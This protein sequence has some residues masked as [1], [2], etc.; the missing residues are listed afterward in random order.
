MSLSS[1]PVPKRLSPPRGGQLDGSHPLSG[2]RRGEASWSSSWGDKQREL[3][4]EGDPR[5]RQSRLISLT[6]AQN[7][8]TM[9]AK[10][11]R[12]C[13][14][15]WRSSE[16]A[17]RTCVCDLIVPA[18]GGAGALK[19]VAKV[20]L[21]YHF[22]ELFR[23]SN[24]GTVITRVFPSQTRRFVKDVSEDEAAL[25]ARLGAPD[26]STPVVLYP[27][28]GSVSVAE[29]KEMVGGAAGVDVD[30]DVGMGMGGDDGVQGGGGGMGTGVCAAGLASEPPTSSPGSAAARVAERY[31]QL[32]NAHD[33][34]GMLAMYAD[35]GVD[36]Y[37]VAGRA[38]DMARVAAAQRT[39]FTR[40][41]PTLRYEWGAIT[42]VT[43]E[44]AAPA[45]VAAVVEFAF[46]RHWVEESADGAQR[47]MR[48]DSLEH[49]MVERVHVHRATGKVERV[50]V[51]GAGGPASALASA[52]ALEKKEDE[53]KRPQHP[54][55]SH[56]EET[57]SGTAA[58]TAAAA[59]S[60][61]EVAPTV[62]ATAAATTA[63]T[64]AATASP[65]FHL[66]LLDG[67]WDQARKLNKGID[68]SIPRVR[69]EQER[70]SA[71]ALRKQ[72]PTDRCRVSTCEA[73][74]V[75]LEELGEGPG[76]TAAIDAA[77]QLHSHGRPGGFDPSLNGL[78]VGYGVGSRT[79]GQ[80]T[81]QPRKERG[82]VRGESAGMGKGGGS[83]TGTG[84]GTGE[85]GSINGPEADDSNWTHVYVKGLPVWF[86]EV[87]L[88][89]LFSAFGS[90][91][92]THV[93]MRGFRRKKRAAQRREYGG[94]ARTARTAENENGAAGELGERGEVRGEC[95]GF[96]FVNYT[97]NESAVRAVEAMNG[98]RA[99]GKEDEEREGGERG[100][101]EE[102]GGG[103]SDGV[104]GACLVVKRAH[105]EARVPRPRP[106][107]EGETATIA[108]EVVAVIPAAAAVATRTACS[109]VVGNVSKEKG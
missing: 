55:Q 104:G 108:V 51:V 54:Q 109:T 9:A 71:F 46:S 102:V 18:P 4:C 16:G 35:G 33:L 26:G 20:S 36:L 76:V 89:S 67:T 11:P 83:G 22:R 85:A 106:P 58:V 49:G 87:K 59:A 72:H 81:R 84:E 88:R 74:C 98:V 30:V 31:L 48:W 34:R 105:Q 97:D 66:I 37:G 7:A 93:P 94:A 63:A 56:E 6:L 62:A 25:G 50:E 52:L 78:K 80:A 40:H 92:S 45:A 19:H 90:I 75:L 12:R 44:E 73:L 100:A 82:R 32:S 95:N 103:D 15:C 39:F 43:A 14:A 29:L 53:E 27:G 3:T 1:S 65:C 21:V 99:P 61:I 42:D 68:A 2:L 77:L 70:L 13:P 5:G 23:S 86:D 64:T 91:T 57:T 107:R 28:E 47:P 101:P 79:K 96:G 17:L 10:V 38:G 69:L 60:A 8:E 24:S 41:G